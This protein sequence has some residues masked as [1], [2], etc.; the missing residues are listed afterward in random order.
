VTGEYIRPI[1]LIQAENVAAC[2][3]LRDKLANEFGLTKSEIK[4]SVGGND[5]LEKMTTQAMQFGMAEL[6]HASEVVNE[7][8]NSMSGATSQKLQLEI[9]CAKVLVPA[10][11]NE[12][13]GSL[14]RIERLERRIGVG[15]AAPAASAPAQVA[16]AAGRPAA[17]QPATPPAAA[18]VSSTTA[19]ATPVAEP[20]SAP[21]ANLTTQHF[22]DVWPDVLDIVNKAS[23]AV[24]LV[25]F[26]LQVVSFEPETELLTLQFASQR[27]VDNFKGQGSAPDVLRNAIFDVLGV[28]VKFKPAIGA[29]PTTAIPVVEAPVTSSVPVVSEEPV[30]TEP[31]AT[32]DA[33]DLEELELAMA[34]A[35]EAAPVEAAPVEE[36]P[37]AK[38][39][40]SKMVDEGARY[41]ESLLREMLG[42]EPVDDKKSG[43]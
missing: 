14:A 16:Q 31:A 25:A 17:A 22:R 38:S 13:V 8:L 33:E 24:W 11:N 2:E 27:D 5:E 19:P 41:G 4:I 7:T 30:S 10:A 36:K 37:K 20:V 23:K 28:T 1:L 6:T 40:N 39:R 42:A 9:M 12:E 3:P 26:T 35:A 15:G 18:S 34:E 21:I 29:T 32:N 43:R